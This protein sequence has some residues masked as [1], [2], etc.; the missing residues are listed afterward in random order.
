MAITSVN[1]TTELANAEF[2]IYDYT[3]IMTDLEL[4]YNDAI[5][6]GDASDLNINEILVNINSVKALITHFR[7]V[8]QFWRGEIQNSAN[9]NRDTNKLDD[10]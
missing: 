7:N 3:Q 1:P 4:T 10:A 2:Q 5:S 6:E 9:A 8:A